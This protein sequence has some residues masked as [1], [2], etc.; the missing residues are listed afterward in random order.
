MSKGSLPKRGLTP[1]ETKKLYQYINDEIASQDE[2][3]RA[4]IGGGVYELEAQ[5][6]H[7][8]TIKALNKVMK[9]FTALLEKS[10]KRSG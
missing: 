9:Y 7:R 6:R 5:G 3:C 2:S 4:L 1:G 10:E 8:D